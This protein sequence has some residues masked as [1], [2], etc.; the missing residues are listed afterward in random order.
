MWCVRLLQ[1]AA[2]MLLLDDYKPTNKHN[3]ASMCF[4]GHHC[5]CCHI[6]ACMCLCTRGVCPGDAGVESRRAKQICC[7]EVSSEQ[8]EKESL[9]GEGGTKEESR[10]NGNGV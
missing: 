5:F 4:R 3:P 10:T 8:E 7:A 2:P 1:S 6:S 9:E